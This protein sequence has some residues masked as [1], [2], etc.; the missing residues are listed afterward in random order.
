DGLHAD[1]GSPGIG[2]GRSRNLT[3]LGQDRE[4]AGEARRRAVPRVADVLVVSVDVGT[5]VD[6]RAVVLAIS[7]VGPTCGTAE[8]ERRHLCHVIPL[9]RPVPADV[10]HRAVGQARAGGR[11]VTRTVELREADR[12]AVI[13][14]EG[15]LDTLRVHVA[16]RSD[17][18]PAGPLHI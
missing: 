16:S 10:P 4:L 12:L 5:V 3:R 2:W 6:S 7:V 8:D 14:V 17:I 18:E 1:V 15:V 11:G 13:L 9:V